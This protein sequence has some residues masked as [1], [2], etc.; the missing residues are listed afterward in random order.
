MASFKDRSK[1][2]V[3]VDSRSAQGVHAWLVTRTLVAVRLLLVSLLKTKRAPSPKRSDWK[4]WP[5]W[6]LPS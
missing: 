2:P 3:T 4:P 5:F 1:G 6:S